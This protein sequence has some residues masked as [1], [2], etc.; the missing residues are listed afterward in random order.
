MASSEEDYERADSEGM[1]CLKGE[2]G[3]DNK[4]TTRNMDLAQ[5]TELSD[6][7]MVILTS[8]KFLGLIHSV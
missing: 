3:I 5:V 7:W 8:R 6:E 2:L 4:D 1:I